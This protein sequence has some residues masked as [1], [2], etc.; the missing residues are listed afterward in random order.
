MKTDAARAELIKADEQWARAWAARD[1]SGVMLYFHEDAVVVT[2]A[3]PAAS[4]KR[5]IISMM[6]SVFTLPGFSTKLEMTRAEAAA[7]GDLG[8]TLGRYQSTV[9]DAGKPA[10]HS[11]HYL[12]VW[13]KGADRMWK[14]AAYSATPAGDKP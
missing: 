5:D 12:A 9:S 3:R 10:T 8:Y 6:A 1:L 11:G 2:P 4:G 7:G 14:I 13:R